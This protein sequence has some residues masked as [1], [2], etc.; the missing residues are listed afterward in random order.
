MHSSDGKSYKGDNRI[1]V[2]TMEISYDKSADA[3]YIRFGKGTF[4]RNKKIDD[5]TIIDYDKKNNILGIEILD[6]SKHIP[7]S[8]LTTATVKQL[9]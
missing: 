3:M 1:L 9:A 8:S 2:L 4:S 6:A 5:F 7:M